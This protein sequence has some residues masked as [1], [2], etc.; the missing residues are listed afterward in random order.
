MSNCEASSDVRKT[1]P[2]RSARQFQRS[3]TRS[4]R[5]QSDVEWRWSRRKNKPLQKALAQK[6][7]ELI[8]ALGGDVSPQEQII[9]ADTVKH[10]MFAASLDNYLL[11]LKSLV[12]KGKLHG[13]VAE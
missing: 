8:A 5:L 7:Q 11:S 2:Q 9:V 12:R 4:L 10:L 6:E 3:R 13:V 1:R